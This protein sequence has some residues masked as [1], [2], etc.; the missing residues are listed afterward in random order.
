LEVAWEGFGHPFAQ[1]SAS[2]VP[3]PLVRFAQTPALALDALPD[4]LLPPARAATSR[5]RASTR[6]C[7]D[8]ADDVADV[9]V[10]TAALVESIAPTDMETSPKRDL[11][12]WT[13]PMARPVL[14]FNA[15]GMQSRRGAVKNP[16]VQ[17]AFPLTAS[18]PIPTP[19]V[20]AFSQP[21]QGIRE[22][23]RSANA[24]LH[25]QPDRL[26]SV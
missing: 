7:E 19:R 2:R 14:S 10:V 20:A 1:G 11:K 15:A 22:R 6:R 9:D 3:C 13:Q 4:A 26:T 16:S 5:S 18:Q 25:G 23:L 21:V 12:I 24:R 8:D 17:R